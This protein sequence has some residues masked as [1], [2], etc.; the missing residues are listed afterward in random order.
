[1]SMYTLDGKDL[2]DPQG[3]WVLE[4][5]TNLSSWGEPRLTSVD[6]PHKFGVIPIPNGVLG[7]ASVVLKFRVFSWSDG[8]VSRCKGSLADLDANLRALVNR[9]LVLGRL[10]VLGF[11][12]AG[13]TLRVAK[14][15]LKNSLEPEYDP[16]SMTAAL[17]VTLEIPDG[18]WHDPQPTVQP[19]ASLTQLS[20]GTSPIYDAVLML[21][22]SSNEMVVTDNVSGST[23]TWKGSNPIPTDERILV[24]VESYTAYQQRSVEWEIKS[25]AQ[26]VS[27]Q[28]SMSYG[29]FRLAPGTD[30]A[31]SVT[32]KGGTGYVSARRAY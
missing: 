31:L 30:G 32:A 27:G 29:G 17:T 13:G 14:V 25:D 22:P 6:V 3:R 28:I 23:L 10:P 2:D 4:H 16:E 1:M 24:D 5:G 8:G 11:T 20:G 18:Q 26:D 21:A 15:R 7:V 12:P 19:L 9:I